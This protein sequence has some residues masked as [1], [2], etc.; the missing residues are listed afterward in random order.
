MPSPVVTFGHP[1]KL[2]GDFTA[3]YPL[4]ST[5]NNSVRLPVLV[6]YD[7]FG[8]NMMQAMKIAT[9]FTLA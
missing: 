6:M 9:T 7:E 2:H 8:V 5:C 3:P 4:S 1:S